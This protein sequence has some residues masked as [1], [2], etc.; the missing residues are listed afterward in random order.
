MKSFNILLILIVS[1]TSLFGQNAETGI[2]G[3]VIN[4]NKEPVPFATITL[5]NQSDSSLTKAAY[6]DEGGLFLINHIP[7]GS[8]YMNISFVGYDTYL[9]PEIVVEQNSMTQLNQISMSPF[10]TELGEVVITTTKPL[11]EV[12]PDKTVFNVEGSSNAIGNNALELLRKSPGVVVDN[13]ERLMLVGKSGVKVYIDGRQSILSGEDLS[14]YLKTLQSTQIEA[15]EIITQ[16][17]S[18]YEAEGNA[19]IINIRL[20]KDRSIGTNANL[21]LGYNQSIHGRFNG[22]IHVNNRTKKTN[23]FG[24]Y[25]YNAGEGSEFHMFKRTTPDLYTTQDNKGGN[26]WVGHSLRAGIDVTTGTNS[27]VGLLVDGFTNDDDRTSN[28]YTKIGPSQ[29]AP[30][31]ELLIASNTIANSRDNFN[32]NGNYKFDNK[33]GTVLN[34]DVDYGN[35]T[36]DGDSFQP[37][38]YYDAVTNTLT[39]TRIFAANTPTEIDIK[40]LKL[41]FEKRLFGGTIGTGLKLALVKT[42]N[43]YEFFDIIDDDRILNADRTNRFTYEENLNAVYANYNRQWEKIGLQLGVRVEQTDSKGELTSLKPQNDETVK[44]DYLDFFPSGGITY[45]MNKKNSLRFS[46]SRRIDRPNYRDLNPFEFKLDELTFQKGN[47]FLRPQYSNSLQLT[48]TFNY[49]LNTNLTYTHTTDLMSEITDTA[50]MRAAFITKENIA[51]QKVLSLTVS[52]P[53][54][55]TKAWNAFANAGVTNTHNMADFGGGKTVDIQVTSFNIYMQHTLALPKDFTFEV[56]GWYNSPGIWGGNFASDEMWS[57]D[58]G[59]QKKLW[60]K[61]ANIK[62]GVQDIFNSQRWSGYNTFGSLSMSARGGWESRALK[63]NFTYLLGNREIKGSRNRSTGLEDESKRAGSG[64]N[65]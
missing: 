19:G 42:D 24:N 32:V 38:Q 62:L 44:Q 20:I 57:V 55:I 5:F 22:N 16:P 28:I 26:Q 14:N 7:A 63:L 37:N 39:D 59:I 8:Y 60:N 49:T 45:Q 56:S 2:Q 65:N 54:A 50:G 33:K 48:Q 34:M 53:F 3:R 35:Y 10:A 21:S 30:P 6:T 15:I 13:N 23:V 61:K 41:D 31:T 27:T 9:L 64:G 51:D 17:S 1:F 58:A 47:P 40:T 29:N 36:S 25:N 18:R 43:N 4:E 12:R 52:Y 46:Y 11:V